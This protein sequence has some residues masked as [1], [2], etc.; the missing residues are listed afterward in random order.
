[1][2]DLQEK[3]RAELAN[4]LQARQMGNEGRARVCARRA[5]GLAA[6]D[7]LEKRGFNEPRT[8]S[9]Y[10]LLRLLAEYPGL[11]PDLRQAAGQ[12]T[13]RVDEAFDLPAGTDL[14]EAARRLCDRLASPQSP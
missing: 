3:I 11:P 2:V 8:A 4:A 14:I 13:M 5:A 6:R 9:A 7:F 10:E 12:L 1:M